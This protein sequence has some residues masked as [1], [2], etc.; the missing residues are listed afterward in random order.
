MRKLLYKLNIQLFGDGGGDGGAASSGVGSDSAEGIVGGEME[1]PADIPEKARKIYAKAMQ[2]RGKVDTSQSV[3][4]PTAEVEADKT[5]ETPTAKEET[6]PPQKLSFKDL[7]KS[8]EDYK[9]EY[10]AA[11]QKAIKDRFKTQDAELAKYKSLVEK[12]AK[13]YGIDTSAEGYTNEFEAAM[14]RDDSYYEEYAEKNDVSLETARKM[15]T[16]EDKLKHYEEAEKVRREQEENDRIMQELKTKAEAARV[17]YP[18]L[19]LDTEMQ[20]PD[21]RRLLAAVNGDVETAYF[22][23]HRQEI[24]QH[25]VAEAARQAQERTVNNVRANQ[26]RPNENGLSSQAKADVTP[27]WKGKGLDGIRAYAEE[28]RRLRGR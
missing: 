10:E 11:V 19:D 17:K 16:T 8:D 4:K 12:N 23:T 22:V 27:S 26:A 1:I 13:K 25:T 6:V 9:K 20:S 15:V 2:K 14:M 24:M 7:L 3:A 21:F 5:V 18:N 28:Q